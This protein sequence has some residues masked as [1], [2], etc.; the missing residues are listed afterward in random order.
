MGQ[1][2]HEAAKSSLPCVMRV[3]GMTC[4]LESE[5]TPGELSEAPLDMR[6]LRE[7]LHRAEDLH[8]TVFDT[9]AVVHAAGRDGSLSHWKERASG[10][11]S[12]KTG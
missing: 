9:C 4:F 5:T 12:M 11:S 2:N 1:P 7:A 6:H 10:F 8:H 3:G